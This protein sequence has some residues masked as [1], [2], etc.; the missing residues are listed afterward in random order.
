MYNF[1]NAC[2]AHLV[3]LLISCLSPKLFPWTLRET[4]PSLCGTSLY[5]EIFL[6]DWR[7]ALPF[8]ALNKNVGLGPLS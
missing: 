4:Y 2:L 5:S 3:V 7:N 8:L 6:Q 1:R